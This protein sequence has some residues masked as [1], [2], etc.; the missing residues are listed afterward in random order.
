MKSLRQIRKDLRLTQ[1]ILSEMSGISQDHL[2]LIER[3]KYK[4]TEKT[5]QK[6][7]KVLGHIDWV[8]TSGIKIENPDF[9]KAEKML[10]KVLGMT[11][12]MNEIERLKFNKMILHYFKTE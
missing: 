7:E 2:S 1:K 3:G 11:L 8:L 4:P 6:I 10:K 9:H 12:T 5:R